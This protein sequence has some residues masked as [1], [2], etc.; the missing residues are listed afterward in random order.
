MRHYVVPYCYR[1]L[2]P[3]QYKTHVPHD[4]VLVCAA[5]CRVPVEQATQERKKHLEQR[6]RQQH[7]QRERERKQG[8]G[9][10]HINTSFPYLIDKERQSIASSAQALLK[11]KHQ[12]PPSRQVEYGQRLQEWMHKT[13]PP[14]T[15]SPESAMGNDA[16]ETTD[17]VTHLLNDTVVLQELSQL[18]F[19]R[20][21]P[22]YI[23]GPELVHR[24]LFRRESS[25]SAT[26]TTQDDHHHPDHDRIAG[27]IRDWR[28]H[29]CE[30]HHPRYLPKGWSV[31]SPVMCDSRGK[32]DD[33]NNNKNANHKD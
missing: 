11:W 28:Q 25:S 23:S 16:N 20:P 5:H 19:R 1:T 21:N 2:F 6:L 4:V 17:S 22:H 15:Q 29:F 12:L 26:T 10:M 32:D 13:Q 33:N 18:E 24:W 31:E 8:H 9:T 3:A 30:T 7:E 14:Q 27:F